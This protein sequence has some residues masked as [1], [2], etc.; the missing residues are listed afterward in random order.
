MGGDCV[1]LISVIFY[2]SLLLRSMVKYTFRDLVHTA[3]DVPLHMKA[4]G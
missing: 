4:E 3:T 1:L 2:R